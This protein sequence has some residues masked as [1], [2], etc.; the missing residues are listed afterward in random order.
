MSLTIFCGRWT[1][2]KRNLSSWQSDKGMPLRSYIGRRCVTHFFLPWLMIYARFAHL[3]PSKDRPPVLHRK[4]GCFGGEDKN[5]NADRNLVFGNATDK[6]TNSMEQSPSSEANSHSASQETSRLLRNAK[7]CYLFTT[8]RHWSLSWARRIQSTL[9]HV[10][11]PKIHSNIIFL[12]F[13]V[14]SSL[15]VLQ[16]KFCMNFSSLHTRYMARPSHHPNNIWW[17]AR[18]LH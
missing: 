9:S 12:I 2:Y 7:V 18:S 3:Y 6:L 4:L 10:I 1:Y 14:V 8:A 11:S 16:P 15:Q 17:S 13:R 5:P